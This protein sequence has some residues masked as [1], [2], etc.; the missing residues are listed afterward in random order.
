M[1]K[2]WL[3]R[4]GKDV[5]AHLKPAKAHMTKEVKTKMK[6]L[7][8]QMYDID[9]SSESE[10]AGEAPEPGKAAESDSESSSSFDFGGGGGNAKARDGSRKRVWRGTPPKLATVPE[11]PAVAT[12]PKVEEEE[13]DEDE[14]MGVKKEPAEAE[15]EKKKKKKKEEKAK[16]ARKTKV[17]LR[18]LGMALMDPQEAQEEPV[19]AQEALVLGL[20]WWLQLEKNQA[21]KKPAKAMCEAWEG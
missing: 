13:E 7:L 2:R 6:E 14:D 5:P 11:E 16:K 8:K 4:R 9:A 12:D 20:L 21:A 3:E 15:K 18:I 10:M 19:M 1:E 17:I